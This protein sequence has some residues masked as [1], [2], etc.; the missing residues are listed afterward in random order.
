MF[1]NVQ[2]MS[3]WCLHVL[4][5]RSVLLSFIF[6]NTTC[7]LKQQQNEPHNKRGFPGSELLAESCCLSQKLDKNWECHVLASCS[8]CKIQLS[9]LYLPLSGVTQACSKWNYN[10]PDSICLLLLWH[11]VWCRTNAKNLGDNEVDIG[12]LGPQCNCLVSEQLSSTAD[13]TFMF[14]YCSF[15]D[16]K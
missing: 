1:T 15:C 4:P 12:L 7:V 2:N 9:H 13:S 11:L 3:P 5:C 6:I 10:I 14:I 8:S 16:S